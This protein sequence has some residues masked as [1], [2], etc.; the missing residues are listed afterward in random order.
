VSD[1]AI[2]SYVDDRVFEAGV[3]A[4]FYQSAA[5]AGWSIVAGT[6]DRAL[7]AVTSGGG[8]LDGSWAISGL[9][10]D[11]TALIFNNLP[12]FGVNIPR[13][14]GSGSAGVLTI[15]F[16]STTTNVTIK[17]TAATPHTHG[18]SSSGVWRPAHAKVIICQ[19]NA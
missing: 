9:S 11:G 1:V 4:V 7:I 13:W 8:T 3:R 2:K 18:V 6:N 17:G 5:P 15:G 14:T 10:A 12:A 19:R 16:S